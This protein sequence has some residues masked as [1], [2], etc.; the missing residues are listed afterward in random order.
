[1]IELIRVIL[2]LIVTAATVTPQ[3]ID[4]RNERTS[5]WNSIK[6][7][8]NPFKPFSEV[9]HSERGYVCDNISC[10]CNPIKPCSGQVMHDP[11]IGYCYDNQT[12]TFWAASNV[13]G[14]CNF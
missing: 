10:D 14:E 6:H 5:S 13:E 7:M 9:A 3:V 11:D 8:E 12:Q 4:F 1:M 2:L